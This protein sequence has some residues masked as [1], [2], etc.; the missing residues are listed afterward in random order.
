[1]REYLN[2]TTSGFFKKKLENFHTMVTTNN[3]ISF[4]YLEVNLKKMEN[5]AEL[6]K[7]KKIKK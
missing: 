5:F 7:P 3:W 4:T 2:V 6:L 1:M